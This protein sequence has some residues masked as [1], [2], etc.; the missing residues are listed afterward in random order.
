MYTN[1]TTLYIAILI[2]AITIG[3]ILI[4]FTASIVGQQKR[5]RALNKIIIETETNAIENERKR[6]AQDIHDELGAILSAIKLKISSIDTVSETDTNSLNQSLSHLNEIIKRVRHI[7]NHLMPA[8]LTH[9]GPV[10]A[11][12]DYVNRYLTGTGLDISVLPYRMPELSHNQQIHIFRILQEII[13]NTI[14]HARAQELKIQLLTIKN[15][16]VILTCDDG[17]GFNYYGGRNINIGLGLRTLQTRTD[18][19]GGE[20]YIHSRPGK[21]TQIHI[22]FPIHP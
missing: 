9:E 3:A 16:V 19:L 7:S 15:N 12:Q 20:M 17:K 4:Y 21:G 18:I 2:A 11:I 6:I 1:E 8:I 5:Y 13:H 10:S 22:E 14:K